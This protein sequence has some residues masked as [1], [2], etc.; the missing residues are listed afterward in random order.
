[1]RLVHLGTIGFA[2]DSC[3]CKRRYVG[4]HYELNLSYAKNLQFLLDIII[5][6]CV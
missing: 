3:P 5:Y 1:M 6:P 4:H 2:F